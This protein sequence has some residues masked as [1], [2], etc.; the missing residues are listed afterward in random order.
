MARSGS[1]RSR[2]APRR[3]THKPMDS[4]RRPLAHAR[5]PEGSRTL[6]QAGAATAAGARAGVDTSGLSCGPGPGSGSRS[7][8][9]NACCSLPSHPQHPRSPCLTPLSR[10]PIWHLFPPP[11][12][13]PS[14]TTLTP[15][16]R[17]YRTPRSAA[18]SRHFHPA[19]RD[20]PRDAPRRAVKARDPPAMLPAAA[21]QALMRGGRPVGRLPSAHARRAAARAAGRGRRRTCRCP[22]AAAMQNRRRPGSSAA[23]SRDLQVT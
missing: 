20:A 3:L 23:R 14:P 9:L 21:L 4:Q 16:L 10:P 1:T 5:L 7:T 19:S 15:P 8:P 18:L 11:P 12:L 22:L 17:R 2:P 13:Q 6:T